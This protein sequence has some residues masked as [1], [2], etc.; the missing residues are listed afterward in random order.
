MSLPERPALLHALPVVNLFALLWMFHFAGASLTSQAGVTVDPPPSRFQLERF[1]ETLVVTLVTAESG[2]R[3]YLG[4]ELVDMA[5]LESR[6]E[7]LRGQGAASRT[8][9]LLQCDA[10]TQ[11]GAEREVG[12]LILGK[13]FRLALTGSNGGGAESQ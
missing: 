3:I 4:R 8:I 7:S 5:T 11:V 2:A 12:E 13:G 10:D 9:V 1:R 6:L